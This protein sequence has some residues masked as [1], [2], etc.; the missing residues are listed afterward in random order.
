[1]RVNRKVKILLVSNN[2]WDFAEGLFGPLFAVFAGRVG[3]SI[4]DISWAWTVYLGVRGLMV[5]AVGRISDK[6]IKKEPLVVLGYV[7]N[8]VATFAYLLVRDR[9]SLFAVEILAGAAAA[10]AIPTWF[11]LFSRQS[12][13][14]NSGWLWGMASGQ[15]DLVAAGGMVLGGLIVSMWSF[16]GLFLTMG[17]I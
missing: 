1:M 7:L 4:L 14:R 12:S 16:E 17:T 2:L 5:M 10:L 8:T 15:S 6:Q 11:S 9:W 13:K 3:G